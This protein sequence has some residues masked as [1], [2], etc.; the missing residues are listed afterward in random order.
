MPRSSGKIKRKIPRLALA[1]SFLLVVTALGSIPPVR[2]QPALYI[3]DGSFGTLGGFSAVK[4]NLTSEWS[5]SLDLI[6]FAI[7]KNGGGQTV[8]VGTGGITLSSG[9]TGTTFAPLTDVPAR[10]SYT[11]ELFAVTT[12][13]NPVSNVLDVFVTI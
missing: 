1:L 2:A 5:S 12:N 11:V 3:V 9:E 4:A 8:A 10:G 7:W 6:V 13:N